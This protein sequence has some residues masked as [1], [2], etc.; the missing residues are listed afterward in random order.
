MKKFLIV[1]LLIFLS[2]G[3][4][5]EEIETIVEN[6]V[7]E[8]VS[9]FS[10]TTTTSS[11][12]TT[13][14]STTTTTTLAPTTTTSTTTTTTLAPTTTTTTTTLAPTTTT[15]TTTTLPQF[16]EY[17]LPSLSSISVLEGTFS[18][19]ESLVLTYDISRG[20]ERLRGMY[21]YFSNKSKPPSR[22]SIWVPL[23]SGE[24]DSSTIN[25]SITSW[26]TGD[27]S[28]SKVD[29]QDMSNGWSIYENGTVTKRPSDAPGGDGDTNSLFNPD[30]I[31][32]TVAP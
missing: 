30:N 26:E 31:L 22:E 11:T 28:I 1:T 5:E 17:T 23:Q 13:T 24:Y 9:D 21:V 3:P 15:T 8:A 7:E 27:Y 2:C 32:F 18:R 6:A 29:L 16:D 10:T 20:S 4:S 25:V 14:S 12:T 19:S